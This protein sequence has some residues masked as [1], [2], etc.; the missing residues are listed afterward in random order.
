MNTFSFIAFR[1]KFYGIALSLIVISLLSPL[2][3]NLRLGIDMT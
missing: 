1:K 3:F 2:L